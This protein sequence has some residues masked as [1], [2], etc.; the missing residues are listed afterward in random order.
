MSGLAGLC[1]K[2]PHRI[3]SPMAFGTVPIGKT[4]AAVELLMTTY[5][6]FRT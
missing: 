4:T 3:F 6:L 5:D 1:L 2:I